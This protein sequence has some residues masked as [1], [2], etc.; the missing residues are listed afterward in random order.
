MANPPV[1]LHIISDE[2]EGPRCAPGVVDELEP[3]ND[4]S[5]PVVFGLPL[6]LEAG[7]NFLVESI[8]RQLLF[9]V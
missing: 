4:I 6:I 3:E 7:W 8:F 1:G 9:L 2:D 5:I